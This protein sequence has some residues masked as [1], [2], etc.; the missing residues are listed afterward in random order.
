MYP[1]MKAVNRSVRNLPEPA[2]AEESPTTPA[3]ESKGLTCPSCGASFELQA[4]APASAVPEPPA[5]AVPPPPP[6]AGPGG[7]F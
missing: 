3:P 7:G 1:K 4:V 5:E 2:A 6:G